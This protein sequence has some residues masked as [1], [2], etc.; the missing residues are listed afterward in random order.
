MLHRG[1]QATLVN[2]TDKAPS[3]LEFTFLG[4]GEGNKQQIN[5][6]K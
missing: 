2:K 6:N 4:V 5:K 1:Q 3:L